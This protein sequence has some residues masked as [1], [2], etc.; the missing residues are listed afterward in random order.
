VNNLEITH[1]TFDVEVASENE[2][3][4]TATP[5]RSSYKKRGKNK[6]F[7]IVYHFMYHFSNFLYI[8]PLTKYHFL[9]HKNNS[10]TTIDSHTAPTIETTSED[11]P[12]D[13]P[14]TPRQRYNKRGGRGEKKNF[15]III[16]YR[17]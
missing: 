11:K 9:I 5:K 13:E 6:Y 2:P 14:I 1:T 4:D 12:E 7:E 3:E 10:V 8:F 16:S 15:K 17:I